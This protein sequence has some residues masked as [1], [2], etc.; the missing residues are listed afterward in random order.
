LTELDSKVLG[1]STKPT[2]AT[3]SRSELKF[4][5]GSE[6][7]DLIAILTPAEWKREFEHRFLRR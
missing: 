6:E 1:A 4:I 5:G 2:K 3:L 7:E